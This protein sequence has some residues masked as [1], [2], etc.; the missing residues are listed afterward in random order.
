[1]MSRDANTNWKGPSSGQGDSLWILTTNLTSLPWHYKVLKMRFFR[2]INHKNVPLGS[3][4]CVLQ[5]T[6]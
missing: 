5:V 6:Y 1:M 4:V 2:A 3:L